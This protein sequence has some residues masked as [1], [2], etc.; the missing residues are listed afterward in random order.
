VLL[1]A[2]GAPAAAEDGEGGDT[3]TTVASDTS[4]TDT[5]DTT[6][7]TDTT[8]T[9]S[10]DTTAA[11]ETTVAA[12]DDTSTDAAALTAEG[13]ATTAEA[14]VAPEGGNP[15]G[16]NGWI[17]LDGVDFD[18]HRNNEPHI[19][20]SFE[21]DFHNYDAGDDIEASVSFF[22]WRP[23]GDRELLLSDTG[24]EIGGDPADG[25]VDA[26]REYDLSDALAGATPN[27]EQG[28]HIRL[29]VDADG[30]R[31]ADSKFKMFW[32]EC[33]TEE[34]P[35]TPT[36]DTTPTSEEA[37]PT[38]GAQQSTPLTPQAA[39][40]A[41]TGTPDVVWVLAGIGCLAIGF[42]LFIDDEARRRLLRR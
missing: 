19:G 10:T 3:T 29:E 18:Q 24:I 1:L 23:T 30:S 28:F 17:E 16:N 36:S 22:H 21:V 37:A 42:G 40:L 26:E 41:R 12:T 8:A 39:E 14:G 11:S 27:P 4:T 25:T 7:A 9:E 5:T 6:A 38:S 35:T 31:G 13:D 15:S 34:P 33:D 2:L 20:C 32:V